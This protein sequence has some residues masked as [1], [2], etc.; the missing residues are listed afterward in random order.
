MIAYGRKTLFSRHCVQIMKRII[1]IN[2][3]ACVFAMLLGNQL[4]AEDSYVTDEGVV[5]N[6]GVGVDVSRSELSSLVSKF[7]ADATNLLKKERLAEAARQGDRLSSIHQALSRWL[8]GLRVPAP[9]LRSYADYVSRSSFGERFDHSGVRSVSIVRYEE[10]F[11]RLKM[12]ESIPGLSLSRE[13]DK[14]VSNLGGLLIEGNWA[15][16]GDVTFPVKEENLNKLDSLF[17]AA[18][19]HLDELLDFQSSKILLIYSYKLADAS[20]RKDFHYVGDEWFYRGLSGMFSYA[21][22]QDLLGVDGAKK[23]WGIIYPVVGSPTMKSEDLINW[24]LSNVGEKELE[25]TSSMICMKVVDRFGQEAVSKWLAEVSRR[26]SE[27]KA[28]SVSAM[29]ILSEVIDVAPLSVL[30]N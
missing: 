17:E 9:D 5:V 24:N 4:L 29:D 14:I 21:I 13:G 1:F 3:I 27:L 30:S 25:Y 2:T 12:G 26:Q 28:R 8:V 19:D 11:R 20:L 6:V 22:M 18:A 7:V 10:T 16:L 23:I 15:G